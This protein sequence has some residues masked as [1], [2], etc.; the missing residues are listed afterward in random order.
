KYFDA[1]ESLEQARQKKS[2]AKDDRQSEKA[3]RSYDLATDD[4][5]VSK[6]QF[7]LDTDI[8]NVAKSRLYNSDL[9]EVHDFYQL[10]EES[11]VSQL[12]HILFAFT[13][14]QNQSLQKLGENN[15]GAEE[16]VG[17]INV[18]EDQRLFVE[19]HSAGKMGSWELPKDLEFEECPVWHD[20]AE[21]PTTPSTIT[22]LQNVKSKAT[23]KLGEIS[24]V[25]DSKRREISGLRNLREAYEKD[26]GLGDA[27][28][29][30]ENLF[31][32][33]RD[34]TML[35]ITQ[36]AQ[37]A[38]VELINATLGDDGGPALRVH[39]FKS[40]SFITP[41]TCVV[42]EGAIWG[43]GL[44]CKSCGIAAHAKCELKVPAGCGTAGGAVNRRKS[45]LGHTH[46]ISKKLSPTTPSSATM[47]VA[48]STS[49]ASSS[50]PPPPARA[51]PPLAAVSE[52]SSLGTATMLYDYQAT[53]A[54]ELSVSESEVVS[55]VE[56]EDESGWCKVR[57]NDGRTGLVPASY[58]QLGGAAPAAAHEE[59]QEVRGAQALVLYDYEAQ[60]AG[61]LSLTQDEYITVTNPNAGDGWSER[62]LRKIAGGDSL[63]PCFARW[64]RRPAREQSLSLSVSPFDGLEHT[65]LRNSD[66]WR[67]LAPAANRRRRWCIRTPGSTSSISSL[68]DST[69]ESESEGTPSLR[70]SSPSPLSFAIALA[71]LFPT[72]T[73]VS[74]KLPTTFL[75]T[76]M[77]FPSPSA[78]ASAANA[79]VS[80]AAASALKFTARRSNARGHAH[81]GWLRS[82]HTFSFASYQDHKFDHFGPLRVINEDVVTPGEGF[83]THH[84]REFE[85]FSY[86]ISGELEHK[87][88]LGGLEI[89]KRGDI[90]M[91]STGTGISHSE[92]NRN[93]KQNVH[94]LQIW[95]LP[96]KS[97]LTPKYYA[98]HFSDEEKRDKLVK[99]VG[100]V[101]TEGV[102]NKRNTT[103]PAPVHSKL[104]MY[105]SILSPGA[106]ITQTISS[107]A[108][109]CYLH[110]AMTSGYRGP[111]I[112]A[113]EKFEDG[114]ARVRLNGALALEE[115]DG[116]FVEVKKEGER[117]L[118]IENT[119]SKDAEF[120]LFE[121]ED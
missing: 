77:P 98:R 69:L 81:H 71:Y 70:S 96:N 104:N 41:A 118:K 114:G 3:S 38:S 37:R 27:G 42:C 24:P 7:L 51:V 86:V 22:Y 25:I 90:Q 2:Q 57:T 75:P 23:A 12:I 30:L 105:A 14:I 107:T 11:T 66:L 28:S 1:C 31:D 60:D 87:D 32:S 121:M 39:D 43:K 20:S 76:S 26:R 112:P 120:V 65:D 50:M 94:F 113:S 62:S 93:Q 82:Y 56:A 53:T 84:H 92:Y 67:A 35:E 88:S 33:I 52:V 99:V 55:L 19:A 74:T 100:T 8:A 48:T 61:E 18:G 59:E 58:L 63:G 78:A 115:G 45:K 95:A 106:S 110:L 83:G 97:G 5:L 89:M 13:G 103:G 34:T 54:F 108:T 49:S 64:S 21:M 79:A 46:S 102:H 4:M 91:T 17:R 9:P 109:K 73:P 80:A 116:A 85:I 40:S 44:S 117:E 47:P 29:V 119:G 16:A 36:T 111:S 15:K 101:N 72:L 6:S 10:L 68:V